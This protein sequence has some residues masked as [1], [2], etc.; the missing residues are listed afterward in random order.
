MSTICTDVSLATS[1]LPDDFQVTDTTT[2]SMIAVARLLSNLLQQTTSNFMNKNIRAFD[3]NP[4][5]SGCQMQAVI[6]RRLFQSNTLLEEAKQ[7]N[8]A[9]QGF[10][11]ELNLLESKKGEAPNLHFSPKG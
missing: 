4:G 1:L 2:N 10:L 8:Q 3:A 5:D 9:V 11:K 6:L 7:L